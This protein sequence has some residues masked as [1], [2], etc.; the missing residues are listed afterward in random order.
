MLPQ[1]EVYVG[2]VRF[3]VQGD[4]LFLRPV[5]EFVLEQAQCFCRLAAEISAQYGH[6]FI[7]VDLKEAGPIPADARRLIAE[8]ASGQPML[9]IAMYHVSPFIRGMNALLFGAMNVLGKKRQNMMQFSTE[10]AAVAWLEAERKR[11]L[12]TR[13]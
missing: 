3:C 13:E 7:L 8:V 2:K 10:K 1:K 11:L 6:S 12:P 9:A 5:G 4:V